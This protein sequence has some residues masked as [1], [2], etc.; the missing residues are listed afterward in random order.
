[1]DCGGHQ[2][3]Q[4][5]WDQQVAIADGVVGKSSRVEGRERDTSQA[6]PREAPQRRMAK[7]KLR[8]QLGET[9]EV[10]IMEVGRQDSQQ[11]QGATGWGWG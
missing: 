2:K 1:M 4:I 7:M 9:G 5:L 8:R 10:V 11:S 6:L 3:Q